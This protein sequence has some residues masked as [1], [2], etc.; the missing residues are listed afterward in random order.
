MMGREEE[1]LAHYTRDLEM[2]R[3]LGDKPGEQVLIEDLNRI[4]E[5]KKRDSN[6]G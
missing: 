5:N 3:Q 6:A 2:A 4:K 1:A